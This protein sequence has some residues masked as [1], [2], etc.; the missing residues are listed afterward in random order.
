VAAFV[1]TRSAAKL[2]LRRWAIALTAPIYRKVLEANQRAIL[3]AFLASGEILEV[4][5][6]EV[7]EVSIVTVV[8][9]RAEA[10]LQCLSSI[11]DCAA[12]VPCELIVVASAP[13]TRMERLLRRVSNA[14]IL[15]QAE[16][17]PWAE[18]CRRAA[19]R[20]RGEFLL[21]ID[22]D[23]R[24]LGDSLR[25]ALRTIREAGDIG[26]VGGKSIGADGKLEAAGGIVWRDGSRAR[27][28]EGDDPFQSAYMFRRDVDYVAGSFLLTKR[29]SFEA[30]QSGMSA[31][32]PGDATEADRSDAAWMDYCLQMWKSGQ[33]VVYDP[34]V[35]VLRLGADGVRPRA[36]AGSKGRHG[37]VMSRHAE[38]I[39]NQLPPSRANRLIA[40][41]RGWDE[42]R[43]LFFDDRVP[44]PS[45]GMG[46]P[47]GER[48]LTGMIRLGYFVTFY[49][50]ANA[51]DEEWAQV[52]TTADRRVEV[53]LNHNAYRLDD[54]LRER[55]DYYHLIF[56]SRPH[57]METVK[58]ALSRIK[59]LSCFKVVYDAEALYSLRTI[60]QGE[61][62]GNPPTPEQARELIAREMAIT[63][64]CT[65]II[66]VSDRES[67]RFRE[68]G[69]ERVYTLGHAVDLTPTPNPFEQR[70]NLLFV[71]GITSTDTPNGDAVCWFVREVWPEVLR[72]LDGDAKFIAVGSVSPEEVLALA[73]EHVRFVGRLEDLSAVYNEARIFVAPTRFAAG[74][75]LKVYEAVAH[76]LPVVATPLL[77]EQL[78]WRDGQELLVADTA[79]SFAA[80]CIELY[81][82]G[83]LWGRL[84]ANALERVGRDCSRDA[85]NAGLA[86]VLDEAMNGPA[87]R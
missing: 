75:P 48:I 66:S 49:P 9:N 20:A 46:D 86:R 47:R 18:A 15:A 58:E 43:I 16:A 50:F 36:D 27:Y 83:D 2:R 14:I 63:E 11:A 67:R 22:P 10:A 79:G 37:A 19:A 31:P 25:S 74:I 84:R 3:E 42:R 29:E 6:A 12:S 32:G 23:T 62:N 7:P 55:A 34:G 40:R 57:N 30:G 39:A 77:A 85:F 51:P 13:S 69:H 56:V 59:P 61:L 65:N 68:H 28:G 4:G 24:L 60:A 38:W 64:G 45:R 73:G 44:H 41:N 54:F 87:G 8:G 52:Y 70:R 5:G 82:D 80:R 71:G 72:G 35:N 81:R 17:L 21:F 1:R 26:V 76:G 78:G 33:R 53:M